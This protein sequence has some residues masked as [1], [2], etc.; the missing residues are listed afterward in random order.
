VVSLPLLW[1]TNQN[2]TNTSIILGNGRLCAA[3]SL[4]ST[5][6]AL[7]V[8][9]KDVLLLRQLSTM[10]CHTRVTGTGFSTVLSCHCA[11]IIMMMRQ[12][13]SSIVGIMEL[14]M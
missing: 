9:E 8:N 5:H 4:M 6:S 1:T 14:L 7:G 11:R 3:D 12:R 13:R 2:R 10:W